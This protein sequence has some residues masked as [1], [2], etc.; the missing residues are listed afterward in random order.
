MKHGWLAAPI[1]VVWII[2]IVVVISLQRWLVPWLVG[3]VVVCA[4]AAVVFDALR[5]W[6]GCR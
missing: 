1:V 5:R 4:V 6:P 3:A 2:L